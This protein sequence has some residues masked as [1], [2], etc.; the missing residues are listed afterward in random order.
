MALLL[1]GLQIKLKRKNRSPNISPRSLI[2]NISITVKKFDNY[3]QLM[4]SLHL[5]A[6]H[7]VHVVHIQEVA[8]IVNRG[9]LTDTLQ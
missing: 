2:L 3:F 1:V 6:E 5:I 4:N 8:E 9:Y 7:P